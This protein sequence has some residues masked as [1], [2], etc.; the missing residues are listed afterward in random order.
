[1]EITKPSYL[2][3]TELVIAGIL[4]V[5]SC[6]MANILATIGLL[7]FKT[8]SIVLFSKD[9]YFAPRSMNSEYTNYNITL[10]CTSTIGSK[11]LGCT[12]AIFSQLA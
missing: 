4:T 11:L 12:F 3:E 2:I 9:S 5:I 10:W 6:A 1:M 7:K 8:T